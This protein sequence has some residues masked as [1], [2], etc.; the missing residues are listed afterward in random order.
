MV[1][2]KAS[3]SGSGRSLCGAFTLIE[4]LVVLAIIGT[5]AALLLPALA[6]ARETSRRTACTN[7]LNQ[8][9]QALSIYCNATEDYFPSWA[10]YGSNQGTV[11]PEN[12]KAYGTYVGGKAEFPILNYPGHEGPSRQMVIAYSFECGPQ[13]PWLAPYGVSSL[14]YSAGTRNFMPTG[15]GILVQH[16]D[17]Q[18]MKVFDCP[19]MKSGATT[20]Y[21]VTPNAQNYP[22]GNVYKYTPSVWTTLAGNL[23]APDQ[24]FLIG[25]GTQLWQTPTTAT[26]PFSGGDYVTGILSSYSYRNTPFYYVNN[27]LLDGGISAGEG[28]LD[29]G[30][31]QCI[32]PLD[33]VVPKVYPQFMTPAFKTRRVLGGRAIC[34]DTFDYAYNPNVPPTTTLFP[35]VNSGLATLAHKDGYNILYGDNHVRWF[36]DTDHQ[37]TNWNK[38][39]GSWNTYTTAT[40]VQTHTQTYIGADDLTIAS[41][42]SQMVWNLFD[43]F[44]RIDVRD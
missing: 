22:M 14:A 12:I 44:E 1:P 30:N 28:T 31:G 16:G 35:V 17:L 9:G 39:D 4:M 24:E 25:D 36:D 3:L 27:G 11:R 33:S 7:N 13:S 34:S 10:D 15:L 6:R 20:Y 19:D 18:E 2:P 32:V 42:T 43:R 23:G 8:I 26:A 5:L 41:P 21:G 37:I 38:W 29:N 40:N